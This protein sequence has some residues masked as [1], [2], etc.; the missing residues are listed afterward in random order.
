M[1]A[2]L[3]TQLG[4]DGREE[5]GQPYNKAQEIGFEMWV[6]LFNELWNLEVTILLIQT[7]LQ[8]LFNRLDAV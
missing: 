6:H 4:T 5:S 1:S 7:S 3:S 8:P 2:H